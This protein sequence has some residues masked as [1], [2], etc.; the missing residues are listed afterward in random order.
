MYLWQTHPPPSVCHQAA[1]R[2]RD[3][4]GFADYDEKTG[5]DSPCPRELPVESL[6]VTGALQDEASRTGADRIAKEPLHLLRRGNGAA[7]QRA[8]RAPDMARP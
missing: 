1:N 8:D 7:P 2:A 5:A 4:I 6:G 3:E